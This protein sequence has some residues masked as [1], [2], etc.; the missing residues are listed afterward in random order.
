M[1]VGKLNFRQITSNLSH[2][3]LNSFFFFLSAHQDRLGCIH[4][5]CPQF[6][7]R[8]TASKDL[9]RGSFVVV[10]AWLVMVWLRVNTWLR[11][12]PVSASCTRTPNVA[13]SCMLVFLPHC[14][15]WAINLL[16]SPNLWSPKL[17]KW[18][19]LWSHK[20]SKWSTDPLSTPPYPRH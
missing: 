13:K 9:L 1:L 15:V 6:Q 2:L 7:V 11:L 19:N 4:W 5:K 20:W 3:S 16:N 12:T 10:V 14:L 8:R 17:S 18:C